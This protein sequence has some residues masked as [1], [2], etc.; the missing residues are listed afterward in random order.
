[1]NDH[2]SKSL[3][4]DYLWN[5]LSHLEPEQQRAMYDCINPFRGMFIT[6]PD[7]LPGAAKDVLVRIKG[8]DDQPKSQAPYRNPPWKREIINTQ[9]DALLKQE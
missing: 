4:D 9:V 2:P 5:G 7:A 1:M 3:E 6:D 8:G